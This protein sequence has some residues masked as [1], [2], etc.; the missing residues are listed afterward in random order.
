M[1]S[2]PPFA[3]YAHEI[4]AESEDERRHCGTKPS[5]VLF[6]LDRRVWSSMIVSAQTIERERMLWQAKE[7]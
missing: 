2:Q 6:H 7:C 3:A 1:G 5:L 4:N